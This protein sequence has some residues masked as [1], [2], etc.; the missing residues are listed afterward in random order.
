MA[1]GHGAMDRQE[2]EE[3]ETTQCG[4]ELSRKRSEQLKGLGGGG[5]GVGGEV[6]NFP[7]IHQGNRS[8]KILRTWT[9]SS[10]YRCICQGRRK[11]FVLNR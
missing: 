4:M 11:R 2:P 5:A 8:L 9:F 7:H 6:R 1:H 3:P 10:L